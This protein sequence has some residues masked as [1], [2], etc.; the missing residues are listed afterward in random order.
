MSRYLPFP[1][2]LPPGFIFQEYEIQHYCSHGSDTINYIIQDK[3]GRLKILKECFPHISQIENSSVTSVR[4]DTGEVN[5][6]A[7]L[8]ARFKRGA[9]VFAQ[10]NH[11]NMMSIDRIVEGYGTIYVIGEYINGPTVA[12]YSKELSDDMVESL[13]DCLRTVHSAGYVLKGPST[14]DA[15]VTGSGQV[16]IVDFSSV[17]KISP[18]F[19]PSRDFRI[20][21]RLLGRMEYVQFPSTIREGEVIRGHRIVKVVGDGSDCI[22]YQI[23]KEG[24]D[25]VL[26]EFFPHPKS[27]QSSEPDVYRFQNGK[28]YFSK[29]SA[30][31]KSIFQNGARVFQQVN[32]PLLMRVEQIFEQYNTCYVIG[33]YIDGLPM[34]IYRD[35]IRP[36]LKAWQLVFKSV[37]ECL[38][39]IHQEGWIQG[40]ISS[41]NILMEGNTP[42]IVDFGSVK[43]IDSE[44]SPEDDYLKLGRL[45]VALIEISNK[46]LE[47]QPKEWV[48]R[49]FSL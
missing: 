4:S 14:K 42:R 48:E 45:V 32:H 40:D 19:H 12:E 27:I 24:Q 43:K 44:Y 22:V 49:F 17:R 46:G 30:P 10:L 18:D 20:L 7:S 9:E 2:T 38:K 33:E 1:P 26:K 39:A 25:K 29:R 23:S 16:K 31:R 6:S 28:I 5:A 11:P 13:V 15:M 8:K 35:Q 37:V 41:S 36:S 34:F 21:H 3:E 47:E